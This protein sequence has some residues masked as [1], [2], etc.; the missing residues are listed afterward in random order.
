MQIND[1][2]VHPGSEHHPI[3]SWLQS[4]FILITV[5]TPAKN[6]LKR[7]Y[8]LLIS[9]HLAK[10]SED[11]QT[12]VYSITS[13]T[14]DIFQEVQKKILPQRNLIIFQ[15]ERYAFSFSRTS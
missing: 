2:M 1:A 13:S 10:F 4:K 8:S 7:I 12:M 15:L 3:S 5:P 11:I 14:Y 9:N 6:Q